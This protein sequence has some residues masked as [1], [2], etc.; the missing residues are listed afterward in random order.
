MEYY[1]PRGYS[2]IDVQLKYYSHAADP[3]ALFNPLMLYWAEN[4]FITIEEDCK[5]F[6]IIDK[7]GI[8]GKIVFFAVIDEANEKQR[9]EEK[10][11]DDELCVVYYV[12]N[13]NRRRVNFHRS[14]G[15]RQ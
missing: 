4:G 6:A 11:S 7:V 10:D 12:Y 9:A 1:P 5:L 2:P 3:H 15:C 13:S 8:F 14:H